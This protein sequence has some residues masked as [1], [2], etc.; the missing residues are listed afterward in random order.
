MQVNLV[1]DQGTPSGDQWW[2]RSAT[3]WIGTAPPTGVKAYVTGAAPLASDMQP[4]S[5][6]PLSRF[7]VVTVAIIFT[8]LLLVYRSIVTVIVLLVMVGVGG[9]PAIVAFLGHTDVLV[10]STFA[11]NSW[12]SSASR[13]EPTTISLRSIPRGTPGGAEPRTASAACMLAVAPVVLASGLTIAGAIF[14]I[15]LCPSTLLHSMAIPCAIGVRVSVAV[16]V[17]LVQAEYRL[18]SQFG[19]LNPSAVCAGKDGD[20][21]AIVRWPAHPGCFP[22][23]RTARFS[24]ASGL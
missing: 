18:S 13:P 5:N 23:A 14:C 20:G 4:R 12:F 1:G 9:A 7:T 10:L 2:P 3:S 24:D 17:T 21:T 6:D 15:S 22:R 19:L 11:V 16:A 8:V